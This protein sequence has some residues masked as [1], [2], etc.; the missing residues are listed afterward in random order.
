M[1]YPSDSALP[2][3][4][5]PRVTGF[6]VVVLVGTERNS[7]A[8]KIAVKMARQLV[9]PEVDTIEMLHCVSHEFSCGMAEEDVL[10]RPFKDPAYD[11]CTIYQVIIK[12][13]DETVP[14]TIA[15]Y[16]QTTQPDLVIVGAHSLCRTAARASMVLSRSFSASSSMPL[17]LGAGNAA[18]AA[19]QASFALRIVQHVR[20]IPLLV[21]KPNTLGKAHTPAGVGM[22]HSMIDLQSSSRSCVE[23]MMN[24]LHPA[25]D[26]LYL[27][28]T[29]ADT[30]DGMS[31]AERILT[32]FGVQ[33]QVNEWQ[34][35]RRIFKD[36][37]HASL[38]KAVQTDSIDIIALQAPRCREMS[39]QILD[40]LWDLKTCVLIWPPDH[41]FNSSMRSVSQ[42]GRA[43]NTG[44]S[45]PLV[46]RN[47]WEEA[48]KNAIADVDNRSSAPAAFGRRLTPLNY[49]TPEDEPINMD[50]PEATLSGP[51]IEISSSP[52]GLAAT[53]V[54]KPTI[55]ASHSGRQLSKSSNRPALPK[56]PSQAGGMAL[57]SMVARI[58]TMQKNASAAVRS[59]VDSAGITRLQSGR[60]STP[61]GRKMDGLYAS[62]DFSSSEICFQTRLSASK[63]SS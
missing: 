1:L 40:M 23:W 27:T 25:R 13:E 32:T 57:P 52:T 59:S 36:P 31:R 63:S 43:S 60:V 30:T 15:D 56:P 19:A 17:Q 8:N 21:A 2:N 10:R 49:A 34:Y 33:C 62:A 42:T 54:T 9:N 47:T 38:P 58:S 5:M 45:E 6:R 53:P 46:S 37:A 26:C 41:T 55:P 20:K 16:V 44:H 14:E 3:L 35:E 50:L 61:N 48:A 39:S 29:K 7:Q 12:G 11:D 24:R 28:V 4:S 18:K 22:L 51:L